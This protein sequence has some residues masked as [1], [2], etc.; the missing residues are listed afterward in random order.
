MTNQISSPYALFNNEALPKTT[1]RKKVDVFKIASF[2]I[3]YYST[4]L[5][6]QEAIMQALRKNENKI[7]NKNILEKINNEI[8]MVLPYEKYFYKAYHEKP[9]DIFDKNKIYIYTHS[10]NSI[11]IDKYQADIILN[12]SA[13]D[14]GE[15]NLL[16]CIKI[17]Y[18]E[19][20][21]LNQK[22]INSNFYCLQ[23]WRKLQNG[24]NEIQYKID[25]IICKRNELNNYLKKYEVPSN[26]CIMEMVKEYPKHNEKMRIWINDNFTS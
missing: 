11:D 3:E 13:R 9:K 8:N 6:L 18:S 4:V 15:N 7:L 24:S 2:K 25:E 5:K 19:L 26:L 22:I 14:R 12:L 1:P 20:M 23:E 16:G 21:E 17:N 10:S